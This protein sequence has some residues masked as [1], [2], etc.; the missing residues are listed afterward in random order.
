LKEAARRARRNTDRAA[1][2]RSLARLS[3][4]DVVERVGPRGP[5]LLVVL[6]VSHRRGGTVRVRA[7]GTSAHEV[8]LHVGN[9]GGPLVP[10]ARIDLPVPYLPKDPG[11][12]RDAARM[13]QRLNPRRLRRAAP[14]SGE[15]AADPRRALQEHP[16]HHHPD[17]D[18]LLANHR[19]LTRLERELRDLDAEV[20]RRGAGL[21]RQF[22]GVLEVLGATGHVDGWQLTEAGRQL[23]R[24]FHECDLLVS[25]ALDRGLFDGLTPAG[26][27]AFASCLTYEH[28]SSEPPPPPVFPSPEVRRRFASLEQLAGQLESHEKRHRVP[29]TRA[30][31]PGFA[32]AAWAWAEGSGL[33]GVLD[34][35]LT[36]G[37]FVRNVRQLGDLLRQLEDVAPQPATRD[38]ARLAGEAVLRGVVVSSGGPE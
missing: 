17:R 25:M 18:Q 3:P 31:E 10:L 33:D 6:A 37:D 19:S 36:G 30:P 20:D 29:R 34:E 4:G 9:A 1:I 38:A 27:A 24:I 15:P 21:V 11:Y 28:R 7:T 35:D 5:R 2:E 23:R 22:D 14:A 13:L 12:R 16:L 32:A 26:V 8:D